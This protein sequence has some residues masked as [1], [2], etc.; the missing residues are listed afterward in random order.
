MSAITTLAPSAAYRRA[1]ALPMPLAPAGDDGDLT[2][3][4][5]VRFAHVLSFV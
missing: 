1:I 5:V 3:Q 4:L 2:F